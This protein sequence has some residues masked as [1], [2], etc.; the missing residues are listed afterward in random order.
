MAVPTYNVNPGTQSGSGAYGSV[1]GLIGLPP[2]LYSQ[3]SGQFPGVNQAGG[4]AT[5]FIQSETAGQVSP[6]TQNLLQQ[7]SAEMGV[8]SGTPG[9]NFSNNNFTESLGLDSQN[10]AHQGVSDYLSFIQGQGSQMTD[11]NL[12]FTVAQQNAVDQAAPN[13]AAATQAMLSSIGSHTGA[14][15]P[16][17]SSGPSGGVAA[18][19]LSVSGSLYDSGNPATMYGPGGGPTALYGSQY[20]ANGNITNPA[21]STSGADWW[22]TYGGA[23]TYGNASPSDP[24]AA[25]ND[26]FSSGQAYDDTTNLFSDTGY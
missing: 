12:A 15:T 10:L 11:P 23:S 3:T 16:T 19:P 21:G 4:N 5:N 6:E 25:G 26:Y 7:K 17:F 18:T 13:P 22:N 9:S 2:N 8:G 1:P 14:S 24:S 20:D